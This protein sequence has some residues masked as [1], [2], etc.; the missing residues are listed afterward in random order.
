MGNIEKLQADMPLVFELIADL[1]KT[2]ATLRHD[3]M[4]Y[5]EIV[6][7]R[8]EPSSAER[9]VAEAYCNMKMAEQP[10]RD[11]LAAITK[12]VVDILALM[13]PE[14]FVVSAASSSREP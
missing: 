1:Q 11:H 4:K 10:I 8:Y 6:E 5:R 12:N 3:F 13:P 9:L 2:R 7:S 14:P